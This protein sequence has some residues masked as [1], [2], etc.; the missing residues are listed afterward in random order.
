MAGL[1][2]PKA[3]TVTQ[4]AAGGWL[5]VSIT[6]TETS[7]VQVFINDLDGVHSASSRAERNCCGAGVFDILEVRM[8]SERPQRAGERNRLKRNIMTFNKSR[9][10]ILHL[11][12]SDLC[13]STVWGQQDRKQLS[14]KRSV[15]SKSVVCP[16]SEEVQPHTEL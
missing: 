6:G 7:T 13:S 16:C 4:G 9:F 11:G 1:A 5:L 12:W 10:E 8:S 14:I 15:G 2:G 3:S